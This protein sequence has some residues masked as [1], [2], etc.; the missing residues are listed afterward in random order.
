[1]KA[2]LL[3]AGHGTRMRPLTDSIPKCLLAIQGVPILQIW[4]DLCRRH[5]IGEILINVHAHAKAVR[6]FLERNSY[7]IEVCVSDEPVLLGSAG[8]LLRNRAW[9]GSDSP[10][11][12]FYSDV[13]TNANL[14]RMLELHKNCS[15]I[16]TL[17]VCEVADPKRCGIVIV[18]QEN[19]VR[20]FVEKPQE[21]SSNLAFSGIML[22]EPTL[23]DFIPN[24]IPVDIGFH[25]L[26]K[27]AGRMAAHR[28]SD[29]LL[30]IGTPETYKAAQLNWPGTWNSR[31]TEARQC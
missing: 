29:Y 31:I 11:W 22:S 19:I 28:I 9:L 21:P 13:L 26:P 25:V 10:F 1:M 23:L 4:L 16:A 14:G 5:G 18:D 17:G 20:E 2:F 7:G 15:Q 27:L 6:E 3:A 30:D 8:T 12:V 24:Q